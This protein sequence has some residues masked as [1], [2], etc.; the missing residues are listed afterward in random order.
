MESSQTNNLQVEILDVETIDTLHYVKVKV[1]RTERKLKVEAVDITQF[2]WYLNH[3]SIYLDD[4]PFVFERSFPTRSDLRVMG[5]TGAQVE[6]LNSTTSDL[7]ED[8][9]ARNQGEMS[10]TIEAGDS[11]L[12]RIEY[13]ECYMRLDADGDGIAEL[14]KVCIADRTLMAVEPIEFIPYAS[15]TPFIQAHRFNGLGL[16]DK[17]RTV[18]DSKTAVLR[19]WL[20]NQ[21]HANNSRVTVIDGQVNI[22]D[23]TNSRP[24]GIVRARSNGAVEPWPFADVGPS[25]ENTL[26]YLDKMRS[27]RGGASLDMQAAELQIAG[28]TAHGVERQMSAKEQLAAMITR[29]LA[30]TLVRSTFQLVHKAMRLY[31]PD[32]IQIRARGKFAEVDPSQW[33]ERDRLNV[34]AGLSTA[35]RMRK[36]LTLEAIIARQDAMI[37]SGQGGIMVTPENQHNATIDWGRASGLDSPE[38]YWQDPKSEEAQSVAQGQAEQAQAQEQYQQQLLQMQMQIEEGKKEIEEAKLHQA[39]HEADQDMKFKYWEAQLKAEIEEAKLVG[40]AVTT[41]GSK[42]I[43]SQTSGGSETGDDSGAQAA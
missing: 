1:T 42:A 38:R 20:D 29:T 8:T 10:D 34:R 5:Y 15:G 39:Q 19:Q 17:I 12:E 37:Q 26:H 7:S 11:S 30:E 31:F 4:C 36:K 13:H 23:V 40:S 24:G 28:D 9:T 6:G 41:L 18:Q 14:L 2:G 21:N 27:E 3:D 16:F 33:P 35:E 43:G 32:P 22:S 25:C